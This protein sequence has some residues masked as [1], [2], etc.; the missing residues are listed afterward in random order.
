MRL[1]HYTTY[2]LIGILL[3]LMVVPVSAAVQ[4]FYDV[5]DGYVS[6]VADSNWSTMRNATGDNA[7]NDNAN[8]VMGGDLL[9]LTTVNNYS[10]NRRGLITFNTTGISSI[11]S[12]TISVYISAKGMGLG[13]F[14]YSV[15]NTS[16]AEVDGNFAA[17]DYSKTDFTRLSYPVEN[18]SIPVMGWMNFTLNAAGID[19]INRTANTT[20][21][22]ANG[23]DIDFCTPEWA[24][25]G[26]SYMFMYS[27]QKS[28]G[29][30]TPYLTLNAE[31][32]TGLTYYAYGD[33]IT[34]ATGGDLAVDGS[35]AYIMQMTATHNATATAD[36]N[37][38]GGSKTS[39]WGLANYA[40]HGDSASHIFI[41]FGVNDRALG[42]TGAATAQNLSWL[43]SN[44]TVAG[45]DSYILIEPLADPDLSDSEWTEYTN[46]YDNITIIKDFLYTYGVPNSSVVDI[47]DAIDSIPRNGVTDESNTSLKLSGD[48][49]HPNAEGHRLMGEYLWDFLNDDIGSPIASFTKNQTGG[50][51]PLS[52]AFTD[53]STRIPTTWN[54]SFGDG[55]WTNGTT[56]NPTHTY[57]FAGTF[58][59]FLIATNAAGSNQ[60]ANQTITVTSAITPV[61]AF[62]ATASG[63]TVTFTDQ[64]TNTPTSWT[65][66]YNQHEAPGWVEFST[67]QN[68]SYPFGVGT[69]DINLTATNAAGSDSEVKESFVI[70]SPA[71]E[72][73]VFPTEPSTLDA[74]KARYAAGWDTDYA[75]M[76]VLWLL[77]LI[78]GVALALAAFTGKQ[79]DYTLLMAGV[80]SITI[81]M[82]ILV[83]IFGLMST[84]GG[85][86]D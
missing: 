40:S 60:S 75:T 30:Y 56:Q 37:A 64:S 67:S 19:Y 4:T 77:P 62:A 8:Y 86:M 32:P 59:S 38:D 7:V 65:W 74:T 45:F 5:N 85:V 22:F 46:Q 14:N 79:T 68:P 2:L 54:W 83:V 31:P 9:A 47:Y 10:Q 61:A 35:E 21:M 25:A 80:I 57:D 29:A 12:A 34:R 41:M 26:N 51:L 71:G 82:I 84:V 72:G 18:S 20:F 39:G 49:V 76:H 78:V 81:G 53:T 44:Y 1:R 15:I 55:N 43:Y 63:T 16:A 24:S 66:Q 17:S 23:C 3:V 33:S 50:L 69:F 36:H 11:T 52:V 73:K 6:Q 42:E 58:N 27:K 48:Y 70:V 28:T 13:A